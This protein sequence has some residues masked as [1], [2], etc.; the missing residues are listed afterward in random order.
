MKDVLVEESSLL[1]EGPSS[2]SCSPG[3]IGVMRIKV[4]NAKKDKTNPNRITDLYAGGLSCS[5][6]DDVF[7]LVEFASLP[8]PLY[9]VVL[10][11]I[12][13]CEAF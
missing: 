3:I 10:W 6:G 11:H 13:P 2:F 12:L 7:A 9:L 8:S 5:V 4:V 1:L